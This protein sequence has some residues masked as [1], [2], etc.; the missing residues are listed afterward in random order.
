MS[1]AEHIIKDE[2]TVKVGEDEY[3]LKIPSIKDRLQIAAY[4]VKLRRDADPDGM[5]TSLGYDPNMVMYTET[6][7][8]FITLIKNSTA[9]WVYSPD[10][11][12]QPS[13][14]IDKWPDNVPIMEV[15]DQFNKELETF[16]KSTS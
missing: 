16:R 3:T 12:G 15:I 10:A 8:T 9:R 6:L 2:L 11:A 4:A 13:I 14:N 1:E 5:V 7:A